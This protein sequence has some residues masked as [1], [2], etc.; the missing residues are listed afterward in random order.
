MN[1][2]SLQ[3]TA[4]VPPPLFFS[5]ACVCAP[6][7]EVDIGDLCI[8]PLPPGEPSHSGRFGRW[9]RKQR[10]LAQLRSFLERNKFQD[11]NDSLLLEE[12]VV[13]PIH[14]AALLG[15]CRLVR[16]LVDH[17]AD[18]EQKTSCGRTAVDFAER[19]PEARPVVD[20]LH[21]LRDQKTMTMR[22]FLSKSNSVYP[23]VCT[24]EDNTQAQ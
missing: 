3:I 8:A 23:K 15:K 7:V 11:V 22:D 13:Y 10:H 19:C 24:D 6:N 9:K 16:M 14:V 18:V 1:I 5:D 12:E 20:Y 4:T 2:G 17:G 21:C